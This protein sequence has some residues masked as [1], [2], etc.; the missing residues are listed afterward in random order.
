[1]RANRANWDARTPVHAASEFYATGR[2]DPSGWFA[3]FEWDDLGDLAGRE[4]VHL[5]CH[6]G[7]EAIGL[8]RRGARVVGLDFSGAAVVEARRIA[9]EEGVDVDYVQA[10]VRD[11]VEH[12]GAGGFDVV[13]TG[14]GAL[15]YL[16]DLPRWAAVVR[17]LLVPGGF[18]CIVEF[19]PL[20]NSLEPSPGP[21]EGPELLLRHDYLEGRGA[22]ERDATHTYTDGPALTSATV[23]YE[24]MHSLGEVVTTLAEA[25]LRIDRLT[26]TDTL[27]WP[28]WPHMVRTG[29]G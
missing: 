10:D 2:R 8:A 18:A 21:G 15:C 4:Q 22:I 9:A 26:E 17:D 5:Q 6:L 24:W 23:A 19:H 28:R 12:L 13:Y 3:P 7:I 11:A 27:P 25:G 14:K 20:L 29:S 1:M 16:P